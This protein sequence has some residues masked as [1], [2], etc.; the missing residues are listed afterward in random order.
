VVVVRTFHCLARMPFPLP[1][2]NKNREA[3]ERGSQ[4]TLPRTFLSFSRA[5]IT[6]LSPRHPRRLDQLIWLNERYIRIS[7]DP[8]QK[9][10]ILHS[11]RVAVPR[12]V[13]IA[14][15]REVLAEVGPVVVQGVVALV[16]EDVAF[17]GVESYDEPVFDPGFGVHVQERGE[18]VHA[19]EVEY[20]QCGGV[21][22][23]WR[24]VV[25]GEAQG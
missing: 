13:E 17:V 3:S 24:W 4:P 11:R 15:L 23:D 22:G 10:G 16:V 25:E 6:S 5:R 12:F 20:V 19:C 7:A 14:R 21:G 9:P 1:H 18:A 2:L 8:F